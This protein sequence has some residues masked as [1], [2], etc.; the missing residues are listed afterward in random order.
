[1]EFPTRFVD[2]GG[3]EKRSKLEARSFVRGA[4]LSPRPPASIK[5]H[6]FLVTKKLRWGIKPGS[7]V[8]LWTER[9]LSEGHASAFWQKSRVGGVRGRR[10]PSPERSVSHGVLLADVQ[11]FSYKEIADMVGVPVGTVMFRLSRGRS[12]YG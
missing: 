3:I 11:E 1:M 2:C 6:A 9:R 7:D 4:N 10:D 5:V 8:F 12:T